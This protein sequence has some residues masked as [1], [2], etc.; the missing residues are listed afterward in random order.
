MRSFLYYIINTVLFVA[1]ASA[2]PTWDPNKVYDAGT[3]VAPNTLRYIDDDGVSY[4]GWTTNDSRGI[5]TNEAPSVNPAGI[6]GKAGNFFRVTSD[7]N[8]G[9]SGAKEKHRTNK[10]GTGH[11]WVFDGHESTVTALFWRLYIPSTPNIDRM[12]SIQIRTHNFRHHLDFSPNVADE[13]DAPGCGISGWKGAEQSEITGGGKPVP[14]SITGERYLPMSMDAWHTIRVEVYASGYFEAWIDEEQGLSDESHITAQASKTGGGGYIEIGRRSSGSEEEANT[15][16]WTNYLAWGQDITTAGIYEIDPLPSVVM[17]ICNNGLDDDGDGNTDCDDTQCDCSAIPSECRVIT[18]I[19]ETFNEPFV[20][21][22]I[23]LV[24]TGW[25]RVYYGIPGELAKETGVFKLAPYD[26]SEPGS[27]DLRLAYDRIPLECGDT[28]DCYEGMIAVQRPI[29]AGEMT[30]LPIDWNY[31]MTIIVETGGSDLSGYCVGEGCEGPGDGQWKTFVAF[32]GYTSGTPARV[33]WGSGPIPQ[34]PPDVLVPNL[35]T[36]ANF[37][38]ASIVLDAGQSAVTGS[39][40]QIGVDFDFWDEAG[41]G[42]IPL[43]ATKMSRSLY[44]N[45]TIRYTWDNTVPF[46]VVDKS[47][48]THTITCTGVLPNDTFTVQNGGVGTMSYTITKDADWLSIQPESGVLGANQADQIDVIYTTSALV[49]GDNTATI[50]VSSSGT[51]GSPKTIDVTITATLVPPDYDCDYDVDHDDFGTFQAC[52]TGPLG[53]PDPG[54]CETYAD[55]NGNGTVDDDDFIIFEECASGPAIPF[56]PECADM[57]ACCE[58]GGTCQDLPKGVCL[59]N[60]GQPQG[61]G[62]NCATTSC[63]P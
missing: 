55:L 14:N 17:E 7:P 45:V 34:T 33:E 53:T 49:T 3:L 30:S 27:L 38:P 42:P 61:T 52:Y 35:T 56:D 43:A 41:P 21:G 28:E 62:T 19:F 9:S 12:P 29:T 36:E 4:P 24:P 44:E 11:N 54:I 25:E 32:E 46:L 8:D 60:G 26:G 47:E 5:I 37:Y 13:D 39:N 20:V 2:Q 10:T 51:H 40:L 57:Q 22:S 1:V 58:T 63:P 50:T 16:Y 23:G 18:E 15:Q 6:G 59:S 31:P 48:F